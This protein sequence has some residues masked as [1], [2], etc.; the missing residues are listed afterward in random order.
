M[1]P[2]MQTMIFGYAINYDVKHLRTVVYDESRTFDSREVVAKMT[3]TGYFDVV[4]HVD[5]FDALRREIDAGHAAVG[6]VF[7]F[8]FMDGS[9]ARS[10]LRSEG[11]ARQPVCHVRP[12]LRGPI[13]REV[14]RKSL[15]HH[16]RRRPVA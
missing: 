8:A 16:P 6:V 10:R 9:A 4:G 5:S 13:Q 3:G 12:G 1:V 15:L 2:V 7:F 14:A 11:R